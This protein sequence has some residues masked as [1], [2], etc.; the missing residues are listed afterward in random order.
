[1]EFFPKRILNNLPL[2]R[3]LWAPHCW[4][5][6]IGVLGTHPDPSDLAHLP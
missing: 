4:K 3:D 1:M 5:N 2:A 6:K